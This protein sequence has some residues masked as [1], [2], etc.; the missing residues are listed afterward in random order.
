MIDTQ[1]TVEQLD[2]IDPVSL[3]SIRFQD[4]ESLPGISAVYF[5]HDQSQ[6]LYVGSTKHLGVRWKSHHSKDKIPASCW[7]SWIECKENDLNDMEKFFYEKF[8]PKLNGRSF[9]PYRGGRRKKLVQSSQKKVSI[10]RHFRDGIKEMADFFGVDE[11]DV[12]TRSFERGY[13]ILYK[14]YVNHRKQVGKMSKG[15]VLKDFL[16]KTSEGEDIEDIEVGTIA[17]DAGIDVEIIKEIR[18]HF[19]NRKLNP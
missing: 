15:F 2:S 17:R 10:S 9:M 5:V 14:E 8:S 4:K 6:V 19:K 7:I 11:I 3:N 13:P 12:I 16:L 1:L 18:D